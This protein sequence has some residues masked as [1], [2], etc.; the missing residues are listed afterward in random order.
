[1]MTCSK[2]GRLTEVESG[3][4]IR[5]EFC[6]STTIVCCPSSR[7]RQEV[8]ESVCHALSGW[9]TSHKIFAP[10]YFLPD[11]PDLPGQITVSKREL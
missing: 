8:G 1:M 11:L 5:L 6:R 2:P 4:L 10:P 3:P 7:V 9:G